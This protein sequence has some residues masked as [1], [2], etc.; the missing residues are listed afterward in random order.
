MLAGD[1]WLW[2]ESYDDVPRISPTELSAPNGHQ[3]DA[4]AIGPHDLVASEWIVQLT[5]AA[6]A[7]VRTLQSVDELLD[8]HPVDFTVI[9]GLGSPGLVLLRGRGVTETDIASALV[10]GE[11]VEHFSA[12]SM[13]E[14]QQTPNDPEFQGGL[15][16][17]LNQSELP[18]A[19][20]ETIGSLSVV[21]GVVDGGIDATHP[22]LFLNIWL[23]QGELPPKFLDDDGAKLVDVDADGLISFY[24]LNN[25][26]RTAGGIV[27]ASTGT[28]A[29][30]S[31]MTTSTPF[32]GGDNAEFVTDKNGN[33]RI[34]AIDLLEDVN[35][36]DGRDTD[37]NGFFDDFFGV[38]FRGGA[39]DPF[40]SNRPLDE[41][42]HG[43]HV[44]GTIGA[45]GDNG[46]GV[47]GVNW[48]TSLMSLRILDNNNQSDAAAAIRAINYARSMR[49][50]LSIDD[51]GNVLGGANVKVLNNSWGQPG[52][53]DR[54]L[55]ASIADLSE[56]EIL[57]VAA[58]GNGNLLGN[59]VDNDVLPF[60]PAG[61]ESDNVLAVAALSGNGDRLA[62]FSNFG[63]QSVDIAAPGVGVRSTLPG[64]GF[65][66]AN[67]TS[68][69]TPQ[70]AGTAALI[71]ST[72]PEATLTEVRQ[73]I[74][75]TAA[76]ITDGDRVLST[77]GRI[78][79]AAAI[80]ADVFAPAARLVSK[81]DVTVAGGTS[82]EF[83]LEYSH[84]SGIDPTTIGDDDVIVTRTWG[85]RRIQSVSLKP[86]SIVVNGITT[87]ATYVIDAPDGNWDVLDFGDY[88]IGTSAGAVTAISGNPIGA[89]D[90]GAVRVQ[91]EAAD[92]F[93]VDSPAD[94]VDAN[95]GDGTAA[96]ALG[97]ATLRAAI[98]EAN[99][100]SQPTTIIVDAGTYTLTIPGDSEDLGNTG[101]LDV[102]AEVT[103]YGASRFGTTIDGNQLDRVIDVHGGE[104]NVVGLT[105][106][107]GRVS[108]NETGG[109]IRA[110]A[111]VSLSGATVSDSFAHIGGGI[112]M[113]T[114]VGLQP[115]LNILESV[116]KENRAVE[117]GG[118]IAV[119][120]CGELTLE[121]SSVA[122][123]TLVSPSLGG[124][125][126][127]IDGGFDP[128]LGP[129]VVNFC[130]VDFTLPA[131]AHI[132]DSSTISENGDRDDSVGGVYA[133]GHEFLVVTHSTIAKNVGTG[134][135][136]FGGT[137]EFDNN[138]MTGNTG[139][140]FGIADYL[141]DIF[142]PNDFH[143]SSNLGRG[144]FT[145]FPE[146]RLSDVPGTFENTLG[147]LT[148]TPS[149]QLVHYPISGST[150][151]D[152]AAEFRDPLSDQLGVLRG[153]DGDNDGEF[154]NDIGAVELVNA[155]VAG[156]LFVDTNGDGQRSPGEPGLA[157]QTV[158]LDIN[159]NGQPDPDEPQTLS[160]ED[161]PAS[162]TTNE[163][164][165]YSFS[166]IL[167]EQYEVRVQP[168]GGWNSSPRQV[169]YSQEEGVPID[170]PFVHPPSL[171][172]DGRFIAHFVYFTGA[173]DSPLSFLTIHDR[174]SRRGSGSLTVNGPAFGLGES[175]DLSSDGRVVVVSARLL[176][177]DPTTDIF[178]YEGA[179][180]ARLTASGVPGPSSRSPSISGD[181]QL[182]AFESDATNLVESDPNV[183]ID[184]NSSSDIFLLNRENSVITVASVSTS[185]E[186][187]DG[188]STSPS[189][190]D[191]GRFVVYESSASNLDP[192]SG[193]FAPRTDIFLRDE[194]LKTTRRI[195]FVSD[196]LSIWGSANSI[197]VISGGGRIVVY[198]QTEDR[199][200]SSGFPEFQDHVLAYNVESQLTTRLASSEETSTPSFFSRV[201]ISDDG[202][203]VVTDTLGGVTVIDTVN[204]TSTQLAEP[205]R[206]PSISGDGNWIAY[207]SEEGALVVNSNPL[208]QRDGH[209]LDLKHGDNVKDLDFALTA[210]PGSIA[211]T[212]FEDVIA[213]QAYDVGE[214]T[215]AEVT[216][217]L[218][219]NGNGLLD[220]TD[221]TTNPQPDGSY[222]FTSVASA[223]SYDVRIDVPVGFEQ[224]LPGNDSSFA[225]TVTLPPLGEILGRDFGLRQVSGAG[226]SSNSSISGRVYD[227]K[228]SN[229]TFDDGDEP[230]ADAVLYLDS[231][232]FGVRDVDELA[233]ET[234]DDGT[235]SFDKLGTSL[236]AV[237][238][239]LDEMMVH[240]S[241]LG[242]QF[243]LQ[244]FPL[245]D[246]IRPFGNPQAIASA[247]FN[248]DSFPD[249]VVALNEA[250]QVSVRL[251]DQRG[252]FLPD[253]IDVDLGQSGGG[254][255]SL[256]V[257][258]FNGP[259]TPLDVAVV[260]N[261]VDS[262]A[263][264]TDF[265][266]SGF[267][268]VQQVSVGRGPLDIVSASISG[269]PDH[270]DLVIVNSG[271]NTIQVLSN[272]GGT[273]TAQTAIASGGNTPVS[274]V[275]GQLNDPVDS[276]LDLA[277]AHAAPF[278]S[279]TPFGDVRILAGD[280]AG[281]FSLTP[282]RYGVGAIP[283]DLITADF[284]NDNQIDLAVA[285]VS[286]NSISILT[287]NSDGSYTVQA[288]TLGTASGAFD[289]AAADI[290]NDGDVDI[291]ASNLLDRN[292]SVFRNA[293]ETP[294]TTDFEPLE[295]VGLGQFGVAQRMPLVLANFDQ[296]TSAPGEIGTVDIVTVPIR[297]DTL[298]V[299][300]NSLV[301]GA[302]RFEVDGVSQYS[303]VDFRIK[304]AV[305]PP[306]LD[307][308]S[309]PE[310]IDEDASTQTVTLSGIEKGRAGGPP[311]QIVA[312]SSDPSLIADPSVSYVEGESTAT[313]SYAPLPNRSGSATITV[314]VTDAGADQIFG[315]G[316]EAT[317]ARDFL[318]NVLATN[319]P[320]TFFF[321]DG[322]VSVAED[323]GR[324][325]IDN[326]IVGISPGGLPDES[327]QQLLD[328]V[329][330][331]DDSFFAV[332]PAIDRN[333]QL[334]FT[335]A[336]EVAGN[337][338]VTVNLS[339]DG[340][341]DN[342]GVDTRTSSF[343]ITVLSTDAGS[344]VLEGSGNT[345]FLSQPQSQLD[346]VQ[347]IDIRGTG[348]NTLMLDAG[349]IRSTFDGGEILV[350]SDS[351][352]TVDFDDGWL[353]EQA[354]VSEQQLLRRFVNGGATLN[355]VGPDDFCNP[356]NEFD[357]NS[358]GNVSAIDALLVINELGRRLFSDAD[359]RP[360]GQVRDLDQVDLDQFRFYDVSA[361]GRLTVLDALRVINQ[362][363]RQRVT[364]EAVD[365]AIE[366]W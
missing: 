38:N 132:I 227:D 10:A 253:E 75:G 127:S 145:S 243:E 292:V 167:P 299:L 241:P 317:V 184:D 326:F 129:D 139:T 171:S 64:G 58:A 135:R 67:G 115:S 195:G 212:V 78:D 200:S 250:N 4:G 238:T 270:S 308:I 55:E 45:V 33:G 302:F 269:N 114:G 136:V 335:P 172:D 68:M 155:T 240:V 88:R 161:D 48:Q 133:R 228:N 51:D 349:R 185:G 146:F 230:L 87:Q 354:F 288:E 108:G 309:N 357:V 235:Y 41:L 116:V 203:F 188:D 219:V 285:N 52:G 47:T 84:R 179:G 99:A 293:T 209:L 140:E 193:A 128:L 14:G 123:N 251:N 331:T 178:V 104:L 281:G 320:P 120:G 248:N 148:S 255:V 304:P 95:P 13:I 222:L 262:V 223:Q 176:S 305:L 192:P 60:Y 213:N 59:G 343:T 61:Y 332:A 54:A 196:D 50:G 137:P 300:T 297:T 97:R 130:L 186:L 216:V 18:T 147:P 312:T 296:D 211:G 247:D 266:G 3:Q 225:W 27:V 325:T 152:T 106:T 149:G 244:T 190:S 276:V 103:L 310:S 89:R 5:E 20:D 69:A 327:G 121:A 341:T 102:N 77:G 62:S 189:I 110:S 366:S 208:S 278:S 34:D 340:G 274:I 131:P 150:V 324:Q 187:G 342:E 319:D 101:D 289:I 7:S 249:V 333:G 336:A 28:A 352:D 359:S 316:D 323:S 46:F 66:P 26:R 360:S 234:N 25:L 85:K 263:I 113:D 74:E 72:L 134:I 40:P 57:F 245:F 306:T 70:V 31:E 122:R 181:A 24:D 294:G 242:S 164:G 2:F 83:T 180:N 329:I 239:L 286:S 93:Y 1:P 153:V 339:D 229:G 215:L 11:A 117:S 201:D 177:D 295:A 210:A 365:A 76:P 96:D 246:E 344:I 283:T 272:S 142:D 199:E 86:G 168:Q 16:P 356:I 169:S 338:L 92:T 291:V 252:G 350:V 265:N 313:L 330:T 53:Y 363:A 290:D 162:F 197:P 175:A 174:Y 32:S 347:L 143:G 275:A 112:A 218:D 194:V 8:Q 355:L 334:T 144:G 271:D 315:S 202:R 151:I 254:P 43:T 284:D 221:I 258:Q 165:M 154:G 170:L 80:S 236:V 37:G 353:F 279:T 35:W 138:I 160:L 15:L 282:T 256:A 257:G 30:V 273:F 303:G 124:A 6:A 82:T 237:S 224:V 277:V 345:F 21:V 268:S 29:T 91:I 301:N 125:G 49:S 71:W 12:N 90:V 107:G 183:A 214:P 232:N 287:G 111:D 307:P 358:S 94:G 119:I 362:L 198:V 63:R 217:Y 118:G 173:D 156:Q 65:G 141:I 314:T 42:G 23:N 364:A 206:Q 267:E 261:L 17:G 79:A 233:I 260:N 73:A 337:V 322:S 361:D 205:G 100:A 259:G 182:I 321:S 163:A 109:A 81:D 191:D 9:S 318:V 159:A 328:F 44:A 346:G 264:L 158:F 311:L 207:A 157:G 98:Q 351:G 348:D 166:G 19:W 220:G 39:D 298:H 36:A 280:G 231:Q 204:G 105:L 56:Q 226:L 22:D 126:I